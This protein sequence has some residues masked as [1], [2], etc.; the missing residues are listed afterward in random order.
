[1]SLIS[2]S[3]PFTEWESL[4]LEKCGQLLRDL[5]AAK[6]ET[7]YGQGKKIL[8]IPQPIRMLTLRRTMLKP[9]NKNVALWSKQWKS[10]STRIRFQ[11]YWSTSFCKRRKVYLW[12]HSGTLRWLKTVSSSFQDVDFDGSLLPLFISWC[13]NQAIKKLSNHWWTHWYYFHGTIGYHSNTMT[14]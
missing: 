3:M 1:M 6:T 11:S 2:D 12:N 7:W 14:C 8:K 13:Y 5:C 9:F 10:Q 4:Q